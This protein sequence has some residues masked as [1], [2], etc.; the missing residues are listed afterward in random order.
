[1]DD[2]GRILRLG[3]GSRVGGPFFR[4]SRSVVIPSSV[5]ILC[6]SFVTDLDSVESVTFEADCRLQRIEEFAFLSSGLRWIKIPLS[7]EV[8]CKSCFAGCK[9]LSSITF[10]SGSHLQR[11]EETAFASSGLKSIVIPSSVE[12]LCNSCFAGC[13]SLS[14][15]TFESDSHLQR[16]EESAFYL[17]GLKS[18]VIPHSVE[19]IDG[20]AFGGLYLDC[21]SISPG[22]SRFYVRDSFLENILDRSIVRCFGH[23]QSVI[24]PSSIEILCK[25]CFS[26]CKSL[27]SITFE[28]GSHLQ[29][30]EEST[31]SLSGLTSIVIP[32][33]VEI[34]CNSCFA[35]C[36]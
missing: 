3:G 7:I 24:I 8:L 31:F 28:S 27:S 18:I 17:S 11:I 21:I 26:E 34:L 6:K 23:C 9:S 4:G 13:H 19:F 33:S 5:D 15:I 35:G 16:I 25:F 22:E 30:I 36:H 2:V 10:E 32:S 20:S 12:I 29:R 14:S 1:V